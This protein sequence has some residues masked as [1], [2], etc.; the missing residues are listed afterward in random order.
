M[1]RKP[2]AEQDGYRLGKHRGEWVVRW[3]TEDGRRPVVRLA[4]APASNE[5]IARA[6]FAKWVRG[7]TA[8]V[9]Q[10][11]QITVGEIMTR[12]I[13]DRRAEGKSSAERVAHNWKA[14]EDMFSDL[15]PADVAAP[16]MVEGKK[17]TRC[18]AH[19]VA[20]RAQN[21]ARDTIA[22]ELTALRTAL[23]WAAKRNL[24][25]EVP[26]VWVPKAGK[27][28]HTELT[29][30]QAIAVLDQPT[31]PHIRLLILLALF[32]GARRGAILELTWDRVDF[33]KRT[34]DFRRAELEDAADILDSSHIKG[35]AFVDMHPVLFIALR[36]A[37]EVAITPYVVEFRG[38]QLKDPKDGVRDVFRRAGITSRFVGLHA[39]R[40]TLATWAADR[41]VDMRKIQ[42]MLGHSDMDT[43]TRVY[44]KHQSGYVLAAANAVAERLGIKNK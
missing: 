19:A 5:R 6:E 4:V 37:K 1:V 22:T 26:H 30:E 44:A 27:V 38:R 9:A 13:D 29:E 39:L 3:F 43:T 17:R 32:T 12:Y 20:R 18:H 28:R 15:Q 23:S 25:A 14:L 36:E 16:Y 42:R 35:R 40:H 21:M 2:L 11:Q 8:A 10:D 24:I 41:N 33:D 7:R 31:S 34:I